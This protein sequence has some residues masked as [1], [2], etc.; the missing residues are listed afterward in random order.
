MY[1]RI[2]QFIKSNESELM[3]MIGV[4]LISLIS[5]AAG[6]LTA[7]GIEKQPISIEHLAPALTAGRPASAN[8]VFQN[9][10]NTDALQGLQGRTT[11]AYVASKNSTKY[12]LPGCTGVKRI[13]EHNKIWFNSKEEAE[14][15]GYQPASNC[16]GL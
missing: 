5:F 14:S 2:K 13:A 3:L 10:T 8:S 1:S 6:R 12:H 4:I 7:P 9:I 16:P 15:L 11:G